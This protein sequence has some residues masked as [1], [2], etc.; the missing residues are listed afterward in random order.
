M[1]GRERGRGKTLSPVIVGGWLVEGKGKIFNR[2]TFRK[3]CRWEE[4][5]GENRGGGRGEV[6]GGDR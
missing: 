5:G 3:V 1:G 2:H 6:G 4:R